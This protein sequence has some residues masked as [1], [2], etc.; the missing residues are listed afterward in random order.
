MSLTESFYHKPSSEY[1]LDYV[2]GKQNINF[3]SINMTNLDLFVKKSVKD[4]LTLENIIC[5]IQTHSENNETVHACRYIV[6]TLYKY[7]TF[8]ENRNYFGRLLRFF[9]RVK[10]CIY[11]YLCQVIFQKNHKNH[12]EI[13]NNT[14]IITSNEIN[15]D[16]YNELSSNLINNGYQEHTL[17]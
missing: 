2:Y 15:G 1:E 7:Y 5:Y 13:E 11:F 9:K 12:N 8:E 14:N 10:T 3:D 17:L 16:F 6:P 4:N